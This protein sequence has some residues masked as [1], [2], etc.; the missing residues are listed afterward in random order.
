M[1]AWNRLHGVFQDNKH[2]HAVMLEYDFTHTD[3]ENVPN[4]AYCQ[5]LKSLSDQLKN[6]GSPVYNS[7]LVLQLVLGLTESYKG[8]PNLF[9]T[10]ILCLDFIK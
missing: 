3:I 1:D 8:S 9:I 4:F 2:S 7:Q 5:H 6:V 10:V